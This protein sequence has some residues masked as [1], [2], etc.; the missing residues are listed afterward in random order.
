MLERD[1]DAGP[2]GEVAVLR[3]AHGPVS[4][5]DVELCRTLAAE[6][7][8]IAAGPLGAVVLT[9]TG[10]SFS[11]GVDLKRLLA[12]G[13]EYV[14]VFLPALADMFLAAFELAKPVVAAVNGHAIAGG[15]VLAAAADVVVMAEGKGRV[16]LPELKVGVPFPNI[17]MEIIRYKVGDIAA[18]RLVFGAATH[19]VD[20]AAEMGLVDEVVAPE[21]LLPRA[22]ELAS[23]MAT[24]VPAD[25]FAAT[26]R[27]LHA[28]AMERVR[29]GG[30]DLAAS[31]LWK[32]RI[33]DG[34]TARFVASL[35]RR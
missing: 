34:W 28:E 18:R 26:K 33:E 10:G 21:S 12:G 17:A 29:R 2:H 7:R 22:I 16:G 11:A 25:T 6:L 20:E 35:S 9:G 3:L 32:R 19:T 23:G 1:A 13:A 31:D 30:S 4:A 5:M 27:Y 24:D 14:D 8:S 15:C